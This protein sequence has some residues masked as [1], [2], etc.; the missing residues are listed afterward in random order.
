MN[1]FARL[2]RETN[3]RLNLPQPAKS[4]IILEMA[5]DLEEL[6]D[7]YREQ[8]MSEEDSVRKAEEKFQLSDEALAELV[9]I[10]ESAIKRMMD[11]LS[12]QA[13]TRWERG[14]LIVVMLFIAL[15]AGRS[16]MTGG[17]I[18]DAGAFIWL[19]FGITFVALL[20]AIIKVYMLYIRKE[21]DT[22]K[23]HGGLPSML[24]LAG[25]SLVTGIYGFSTEVYLAMN[26]IV[27][28]MDNAFAHLIDLSIG[29]SSLFIASLLS[30]LGIA[31]AWFVLVNRVLSIEREETAYLLEP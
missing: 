28:D 1:R 22:R 30:T 26:R 19:L 2:L 21:H 27:N 13:R 23:L 12:E 5:S 18:T 24:L 9:S 3:E 25:A 16:I 10:H 11:R 15:M 7:H 31:L 29:G 4:R 8:G 14:I 6:F 17:F 20:I